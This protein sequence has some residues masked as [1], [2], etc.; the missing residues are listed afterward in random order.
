MQAKKNSNAQ[1]SGRKPTASRIATQQ[2]QHQQHQQQIN[3]LSNINS[4]K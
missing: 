2:H 3:S 1:I 4:Y